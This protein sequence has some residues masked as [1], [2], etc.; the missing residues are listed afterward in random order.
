MAGD[1]LVLSMTVVTAA[2]AQS[3]STSC[4]VVVIGFLLPDKPEI[5]K[6]NKGSQISHY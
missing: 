4:L 1:T 2:F 3:A 6:Q 5:K